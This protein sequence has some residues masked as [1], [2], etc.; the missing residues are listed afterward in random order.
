MHQLNCPPVVAGRVYD[1][2]IS[3]FAFQSLN[4]HTQKSDLYA[5]IYGSCHC[6][7]Q[8]H[9]PLSNQHKTNINKKTNN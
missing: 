9:R 8:N 1:S 4:F 3:R 7:K 6:V 2:R 5:S